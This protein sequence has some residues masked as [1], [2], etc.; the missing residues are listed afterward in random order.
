G[1]HLPLGHR[2]ISGREDVVSLP[3][4]AR[5]GADADTHIHVARRPAERSRVALSGDANPLAV[6]DSGGDLHVEV[7]LG[8]HPPVASADATRL[9]DHAPGAPA[10]RAGLRAH[11]LA[12]ER[13]RDLLQAAASRACGTRDRARARLR[14]GSAAG[15]AGGGDLERD[16][17]R[18]A[19]GRLHQVD[20]DLRPDIRTSVTATALGAEEVIAEEGSE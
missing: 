4:E 17:L 8:E 14:A 11:E 19:V 3:D 10:A 12:E 20:P 15:F 9:L 1:A 13:P 16:V 6:V 7:P 18:R 5:I 2:Q